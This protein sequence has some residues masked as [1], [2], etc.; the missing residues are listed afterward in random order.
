MESS[1]K[2]PK[3]DITNKKDFRRIFTRKPDFKIYNTKLDG[4]GVIYEK[5][6]ACEYSEAYYQQHAVV[7]HLRPEQ[8]SLRR[9]GDSIKVENVNIGDVAIIPA[10]VNHWQRIETDVSEGIIITI[11]PEII[12]N[13]AHETIDPNKIQLLPTFSKPDPFLQYLALNLKANLDSEYYDKFYAESL[14]EALSMHLLRHYTT[15]KLEL[16]NNYGGLPSNKLNKAMEYINDNLDRPINLKDIAQVTDLSLFY[17]SHMFKESL[18]ISPYQYVIQ[19]RIAKVKYLLINTKMSLS[20]IT[21]E[22]G[23]SSQSQMTKHFR[24]H[25]GVT[26]R[27]YLLKNQ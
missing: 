25:V 26:P 11:E 4:K 24:K 21:Y 2:I 17:F 20:D 10:D 5:H 12:A 6:P 15:Q 9:L 19:Q 8:G 14:F 18:G 13:I 27:V 23:F 22:C 16:E 1:D 3:L 7:V